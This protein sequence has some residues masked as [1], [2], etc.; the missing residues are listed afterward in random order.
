ML[1]GR[2]G[3]LVAGRSSFERSGIRLNMEAISRLIDLIRSLLFKCQG[4]NR[5]FPCPS[6]A[7]L[8]LISVT[9]VPHLASCLKGTFLLLLSAVYICLPWLHYQPKLEAPCWFHR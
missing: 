2:L 9:M 4:F 8:V 6:E 1:A 3:H 7:S 5:S